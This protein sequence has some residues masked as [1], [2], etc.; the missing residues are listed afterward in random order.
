MISRTID[1][2]VSG[3]AT[4]PSPQTSMQGLPPSNSPLLRQLSSANQREQIL[5]I[6]HQGDVNAAFQT[7]SNLLH[8]LVIIVT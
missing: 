8:F 2:K 3:I 6:L 5:K 7:V 1:E 4:Q